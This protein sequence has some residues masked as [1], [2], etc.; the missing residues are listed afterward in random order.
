MEEL[1]IALAVLLGPLYLIIVPILVII[2]LYRSSS[3]KGDISRMEKSLAKE[4]QRIWQLENQ[5]AEISV[6]PEDSLTVT[7]PNIPVEQHRVFPDNF[8]MTSE[9]ASNDPIATEP[10]EEGK[11]FTLSVGG[12]EIE[13]EPVTEPPFE[14]DTYIMSDDD[15]ASVTMEFE[16]IEDTSHELHPIEN[17]V[18]PAES[19]NDIE[20]TPVDESVLEVKGSESTKEIYEPIAVIEETQNEHVIKSRSEESVIS[21]VQSRDKKE[22]LTEIQEV[23]KKL[24]DVNIFVKLGL[25]VLF[26]GLAFFLKYA[27]DNDLFKMPI[28]FKLSIVGAVG[29]AVTALGWKLRGKK[30]EYALLLQ[31]GGVGI[32]Y[33]TIFA[34][35]KILEEFPPPVALGLMVAV[36]IGAAALA[37]LQ[38]ARGLAIVSV[39]GGFMAPLLAPTDNPSHV[40]LFSYYLVLNLVIFAIT[41]FKPWKLLTTIGFYFTFVIA[42]LWGV[43]SYNPEKFASTEPFLLSYWVLYIGLSLFYAFRQPPKLRGIVD[44]TL[45]FGT[46]VVAFTLQS[47]LIKEIE[48]GVAFSALIAAVI[49]I[50]ISL[51]LWKKGDSKLKMLAESFLAVGVIFATL[52]IPFAVSGELTSAAWA[53]EGAGILWVSLKQKRTYA[54]R[55]G[56]LLQLLSLIFFLGDF[57]QI[58]L[59]DTLFLNGFTL[60]II[61]ISGAMFASSY[62]LKKDNFHSSAPLMMLATMV[63]LLGG[64]IQIVH[65]VGMD[66]PDIYPMLTTLVA[67]YLIYGTVSLFVGKQL[68]WEL[69]TNVSLLTIPTVLIGYFT[70]LIVDLDISGRFYNIDMAQQ[71]LLEST[72]GI[73][74]VVGIVM[75][76]IQLAFAPK[77]S[78]MRKMHKAHHIFLLLFITVLIHRDGWVLLNP[79]FS[80]SSLWKMAYVPVVPLAMVWFVMKA[81]IRVIDRYRSSILH[82]VGKTLMTVL[83][84]WSFAV[85][86]FNGTQDGMGYIPLL[87]PLDIIQLVAL[88]TLVFWWRA[89]AIPTSRTVFRWLS[90]FM[91]LWA[92]AI[93][94][95]SISHYAGVSYNLIA[96][97][98]SAVAQGVL[99]IFWTLYGT[100]YLITGSKLYRRSTW[101]GGASLLGVVTLKLLLNILAEQSVVRIIT[102]IVVGIIFMV[103]GYFLPF[104]QKKEEVELVT[105]LDNNELDKEL[106]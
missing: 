74:V 70:H 8:E 5:L 71:T 35:F 47:I 89:A 66:T 78:A 63:S 56:I 104:P 52:A 98:S 13:I 40:A 69:L 100:G 9:M 26:L 21:L 39:V 83:T 73:S 28:E 10:I 27:V 2:A 32:T 67:Y 97:L 49:Y 86:T 79:H 91:F 75:W 76:Y 90:T 16:S 42:T 12:K 31:G 84:L 48:F 72:L 33:L 57:A 17:V 24:S 44:G 105:P 95:R 4:R 54:R 30:Q 19:Y 18:Q 81:P 41:N 87:N 106:N 94:M 96:M 82:V 62:W 3:F 85:L 93:V 15:K 68:K 55:F 1:L 101:I 60:G 29:V 36:G 22:D 80:D 46:P 64:T 99:T 50:A 59:G 11:S 53:L 25:G 37:I 43:A 20:I 61:M 51:W 88:I 34:S 103:V 6:S 58:G 14:D 77:K 65:H 23:M 102:F 45:L 7:P 38:N 92:N